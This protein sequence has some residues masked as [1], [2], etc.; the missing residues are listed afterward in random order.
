MRIS[1]TKKEADLLWNILQYTLLGEISGGPI[2]PP[3]GE[4]SPEADANIA[5]V[6]NILRKIENQSV[7]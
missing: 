6:N 2:E 4:D 5:A 7:S 3:E 1:L